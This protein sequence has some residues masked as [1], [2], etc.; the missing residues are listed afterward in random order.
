MPRALRAAV[1]G[2]IVGAVGGL[3][4]APIVPAWVVL[5]LRFVGGDLVSLLFLAAIL[6]GLVSSIGFVLGLLAG[7]LYRLAVGRRPPAV[8]PSMTVT[9]R[10]TNCGR[11]ATVHERALSALCPGCGEPLPRV[12][13]E[14]EGRSGW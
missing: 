8:R 4:V 2:G 6:V 7:S 1:V 11:H 13:R 14:A 10:C 5:T 9:P 3:V 12:L